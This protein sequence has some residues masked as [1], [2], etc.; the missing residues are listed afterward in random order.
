[1]KIRKND[2]V[3]VIEGKNKG[4]TVEGG[5]L[6]MKGQNWFPPDFVQEVNI[7]LEPVVDEIGVGNEFS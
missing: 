2:N 1:M 6:T 5:L 4:K 3:L 7:R